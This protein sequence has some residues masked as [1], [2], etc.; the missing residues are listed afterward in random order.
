MNNQLQINDLEQYC[1][2]IDASTYKCVDKI[3][4]ASNNDPIDVKNLEILYNSRISQ[5]QET[6]E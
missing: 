1:S 5:L 3:Q 2:S 4:N 6:Q